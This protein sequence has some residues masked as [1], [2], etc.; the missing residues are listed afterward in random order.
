MSLLESVY[1]FW[2]FICLY[3]LGFIY[4]LVEMNRR[5]P[6]LYKIRRLDL[7]RDLDVNLSKNVVVITGG[8]TGIGLHTAK[9]LI[10]RGAHVIITTHIKFGSE[11]D[12]LV[13]Q[14]DDFFQNLK[15]SFELWHLELSSFNS[16]L[17]FIERF[18]SSGLAL[19]IL[20]NNAGN[21]KHGLSLL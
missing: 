1:Q 4:V 7:N 9:H 14:L 5:F 18:R 10:K 2:C 20:I 21:F 6:L 3:A 13:K 16:V 11:F 8:S 17:S 19:N 15:G 12:L